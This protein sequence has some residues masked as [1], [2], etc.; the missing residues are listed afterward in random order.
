MCAHRYTPTPVDSKSAANLQP[1]SPQIGLRYPH[2]LVEIATWMNYVPIGLIAFL[3]EV[4]FE[5]DHN[6]GLVISA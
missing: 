5:I 3:I 1:F 6:L 2:S 4:I